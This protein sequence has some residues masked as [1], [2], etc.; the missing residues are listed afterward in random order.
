MK[1]L[2]LAVC[3]LSLTLF[4][5][6]KDTAPTNPTPPGNGKKVALNIRT[7]D[8]LQRVEPL[9]GSNNKIAGTAEALRDSALAAKVSHLYYLLYDA[10]NNLVSQMHQDANVSEDFGSFYDTAAPGNYTMVLI[11]SQSPIN[12]SSSGQLP[13]SYFWVSKAA[14]G[15]IENMPDIFYTKENVYVP[16]DYGS[17]PLELNMTLSR[18]VGNLQINILDMP[19]PGSGDT[20][21]SIKI[22]PEAPAF[23]FDFNIAHI[24]PADTIKAKVNRVSLNTF[25]AYVLNTV[26]PLTV[27]INYVDPATGLPQTKVINNINCYVNRRTI[28]SGYLYGGSEPAN[29]GVKVIL[30]DSWSGDDNQVQF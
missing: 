6:K 17:E 13:G 24:G 10:T 26:A 29:N 9:P 1:K 14:S 22:T 3:A 5:C 27:T 18:V 28:L 7:K 8:F 19:Q 30:L 23:L 25:S 21:V 12:I 11:A 4:A 20:S 2:L 16:D 15:E